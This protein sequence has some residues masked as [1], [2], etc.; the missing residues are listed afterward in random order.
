MKYRFEKRRKFVKTG[1]QLPEEVFKELKKISER[2]V[3]DL[4]IVAD[5]LMSVAI[6]EYW[7]EREEGKVKRIIPRR[8]KPESKKRVQLRTK[9]V[10]K[11]GQSYCQYIQCP[12][13]GKSYLKRNMVKADG[14]VFCSDDCKEN[15][16]ND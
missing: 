9:A 2:E 5:V 7:E 11:G 8:R 10:L 13:K 3:V 14:L 12:D 16:L 15:Y 6:K 4:K 1:I